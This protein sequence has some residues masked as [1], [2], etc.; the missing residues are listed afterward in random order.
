MHLPERGRTRED[1]LAEMEA[2]KAHDVEW[3][4]GRVFSLVYYAGDDVV[5]LLKDAS[6]LFFSENALNPT[7]F[8]SLRRM[9]TEVVKM[10]ASL[11]H[12][13]EQVVGNMTSGGTESLLLVMK[14]ARDWGKA[15]KRLTG[16]PEVVL[17][18]TAHPAFE[19]AAHYFG[20]RLVRTPVDSTFRADVDA[21]K[22]AITPNTVMIVGSA[23]AYPQG[24]L[25]PI[26][27]MGML[28]QTHELLMHVDA[29]VGGYML[30]FL[31]RLGYS[32]PPF[33]FRVPGVTS[34]SA[35]VHK[36]GYAAKGASVILYR[37][38]SIR[39]HQFFVSTEWPGG[40]YAS[41]ALGGTRPGGPIAAAWAVMNYL[42][43]EGYMRLAQTV[44]ETTERLQA[45]IHS[46]PGLEILGEPIMSVFAVGSRQYDV[47]ELADE[48]ELRGWHMDR[49]HH[50]PSLHFT[51]SPVHAQVVDT[52][53]HD[54]EASIAVLKRPSLR[55]WRDRV[56]LRAGS[57]LLPRLP[58][59]WRAK[60]RSV[61]PSVTEE[62]GESKGRSAPMY[63]LM[64]TLPT[65]EDVREAVLDVL[66]N[67]FK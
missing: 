32:I 37:N 67:L 13:D 19:K 31:E 2:M 62:G 43:M 65:R 50:P 60:L 21:M 63:G 42:G 33:D 38:A 44:M 14:A 52:F 28:A 26:E 53:L 18:V 51:I 7:A 8:P 9:E 10:T 25:D 23:P 29:C 36:Y 34:I 57:G 1:V 6:Q 49:Q 41:P 5:R 55:R 48:M 35:D 15:H 56:L 46:L 40:I 45:G 3:Q 54:L 59:S 24:V 20:I 27:E 30:P 66:D 22:A 17:P 61:L 64:A 4:R 39:R 58:R 47:Y 11:L 12:G 16:L